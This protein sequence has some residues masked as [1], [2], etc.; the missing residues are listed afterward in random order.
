MMQIF[1][2]YRDYGCLGSYISTDPHMVIQNL[3]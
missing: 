2:K 1:F 3:F